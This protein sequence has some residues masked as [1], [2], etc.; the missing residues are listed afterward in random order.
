[1]IPTLYGELLLPPVRE[2][3]VHEAQ[4]FLELV[5]GERFF[6]VSG[7]A[8]GLRL[9]YRVIVGQAGDHRARRTSARRSREAPRLRADR[10]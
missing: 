10:C 2:D 7:H 3:S 6:D 8:K 5:Q 9:G 4:L 1:M